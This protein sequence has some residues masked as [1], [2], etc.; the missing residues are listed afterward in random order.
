[1][2]RTTKYTKHTNMIFSVFYVFRGF[3]IYN[4][5]MLALPPYA[6][7]VRSFPCGEHPFVFLLP[8]VAESPAMTLIATPAYPPEQLLAAARVRI[9][10][11]K[12]YVWVDDEAPAIVLAESYYR[13]GHA[14]DLYL[15]LLHELT[16][17]RQLAEGRNIW[18]ERLR[19]V[20][21]PTEIE[22][23]AIAIGEG[24]RLG[25]SERQIVRHLSNPWMTE[26]DIMRLR[27][28]VRLF[29]AQRPPR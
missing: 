25:M 23:Y 15:D 10:P 13:M 17:L 21:R 24:R 27:E 6:R 20:D 5:G 16:H 19:Y 8:R 11:E 2:R 18:D 3:F 9:E 14:R 29:L 7:V 4:I 28:N 22:G 1:M 26:G 12:G